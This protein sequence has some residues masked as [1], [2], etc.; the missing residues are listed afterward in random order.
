MGDGMKKITILFALS[1]MLF[2]SNLEAQDANLQEDFEQGDWTLMRHTNT[3]HEEIT[4][5]LCLSMTGNDDFSFYIRADKR[6]IELRFVSMSWNLNSSESGKIHIIT[7]DS[8]YDFI[9]HPA[10]TVTFISF[11]DPY[12]AGKLL[13]SLAISNTAKIQFGNKT[14]KSI[15]LSGSSAV[16]SQFQGCVQSSGFAN[17]GLPVGNPNSP[18]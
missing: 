9:A 11:L 16:L 13:R 4:T 2:S 3:L 6:D 5:D 15:S 1:L 7:N 18:F 14:S 12:E 10:D 8:T 17:L